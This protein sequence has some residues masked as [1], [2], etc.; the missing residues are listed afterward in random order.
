MGPR[1]PRCHQ[2]GMDARRRDA[3]KANAL[4]RSAT[5]QT[6]VLVTTLRER[7]ARGAGRCCFVLVCINTRRPRRLAL[8]HAHPARGHAGS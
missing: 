7:G 4:A 5:T 1:E 6:P 2:N 8:R 3:A